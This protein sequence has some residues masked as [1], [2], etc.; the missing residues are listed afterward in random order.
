MF[1]GVCHSNLRIG[2]SV[3][4]SVDSFFSSMKGSPVEEPCKAEDPRL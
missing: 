3:A 4:N 2:A 1:I